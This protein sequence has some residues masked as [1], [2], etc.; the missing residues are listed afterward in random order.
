MAGVFDVRVSKG[1]PSV[2]IITPKDIPE[3]YYNIPDPVLDKRKVLDAEKEGIEVPGTE[4]RRNT[5]LRIR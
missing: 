1:P 4:V 3:E 2:E 5:H